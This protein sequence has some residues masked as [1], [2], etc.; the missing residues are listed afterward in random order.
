MRKLIF[1]VALT[2][3][4]HTGSHAAAIE[5]DIKLKRVILFSFIDGKED[6]IEML[7]DKRSTTVHELK[8]VYA[9]RRGLNPKLIGV[10]AVTNHLLGE[11]DLSPFLCDDDILGIV[12]KERDADSFQFFLSLRNVAKQ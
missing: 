7:I 9:G 8:T 5:G 3:I 11:R 4:T 1:A 12:M 2:L 6:A 10:K